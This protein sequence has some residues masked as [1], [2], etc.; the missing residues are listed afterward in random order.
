MY[1][2][3]IF[4]LK[5]PQKYSKNTA[6]KDFTQIINSFFL[7]NLPGETR[8]TFNRVGIKIKPNYNEKFRKKQKAKVK[9]KNNF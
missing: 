9:Q 5:K 2:I 7:N 8:K 6:I 3:E 1:Y 4:R